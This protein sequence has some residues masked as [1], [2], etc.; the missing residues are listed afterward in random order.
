VEDKLATIARFLERSPEMD[1]ICHDECVV[2]GAKRKYLKCGPHKDYESL[3]FK[4]NCISTSA[5]VVKRQKVLEV[6]GFSENPEINGVE[7]YD[8]WLRLTR[9]GCRIDYLHE[10]LG[11]YR[12]HAKG[13]SHDIRKRLTGS[14][15]VLESHFRHWE[16]Q[17]A[18]FRYLARKRRSDAFRAAARK[19]FQKREPK[20]FQRYLFRALKENPVSWKG[21]LLATLALRQLHDRT[22]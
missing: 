21:W 15:N 20:E 8:F 9:A 11:V 18:F 16:P 3:L 4:G 1:L 2:A 14:L 10:I 13:I 12:V 6:G 22:P 17:D 19:S 7:D 5:T